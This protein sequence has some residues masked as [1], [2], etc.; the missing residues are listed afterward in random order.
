MGR[1][2]ST[3]QLPA[4]GLAILP[5]PSIRLVLIGRMEAWSLAST[6]VLPRGRKARALLAVLGLAG[7]EPVP[8]ARLAG[9]LWSGRGADQQRCSLRQALHEVQVA[10]AGAGAPPLRPGR[11]ALALPAGQVW[12][13]ALEVLRADQARPDALD[14]L[15]AELLADLDGLDPAFDTWLAEQRRALRAAAAGLATRLL[16]AARGPEA[17]ARAARRLVALDPAQEAACR[18]LMRAEAALG[19]RGAALAAFEACRALLRDRH[20]APPSAETLALA[21]ALR[22]GAAV[23]PATAAA[24]P[25]AEAPPRRAA[26]RGARIGVLPLSA[27]GAAP[28][29]ARVDHLAVGLAE[30][31]TAALACLRW[32]FVVD[33][34]SLAAAA[35]REGAEAAA[36]AM[37]LDFLL[38]GSV[39]QTAGRIRV[40]LRLTDLRPPG[41]VVWTQRLERAADD[42][43]ALQDEIAAAVVARIDPEILLIEANR[44]GG[45]PAIGASAYDLLLRAIPALHRL[46][47]EGFLAAGDRLREAVALEPEYAPALAWHAYWHMIL[48]GQGWAGA[49]E[50]KAMAAAEGLASRAVALDPLDAQA[51]TILGHVHAFLHHRVEEAAALH[52]RALSLNPN[53]AMAWVFLGMA[54]SYLGDHAGGLKRLDRYRDLAP[55]HPHGFFFDAARGVPLLLSG[56]H[57]E[58]AGICR[59]AIALQPGFSFPQKVLLAALGHLGEA[60]EAAAV[61]ARLLAIEPGFTVAQALA[62][63]PLRQAG[64]RAHYARGLRLAGLG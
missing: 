8:R 13:D 51:L 18:A 6:P 27:P 24:P 57:A 37:A 58:A 30:E 20:G 33:C 61:K 63:T 54:E 38:A 45:R 49:A 32:L 25:P 22:Q 46:D 21:E 16:A 48:L 15:G 34:A 17:A 53:L 5:G 59:A 60:A 23:L 40:S 36:R 28:G 41:G 62:R 7:G 35:A 14:L 52:R 2:L 56:R 42:L 43:V 64:D 4:P 55:C 9:L 19:D 31:M 26:A 39:Q 10:L 1:T 11:D 44:A 3:S 12:V 47:R 50:A 29:A